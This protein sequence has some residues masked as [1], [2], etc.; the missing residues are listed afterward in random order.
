MKQLSLLNL[1]NIQPKQTTLYSTKDSIKKI[2]SFDIIGKSPYKINPARQTQ[3]QL[4]KE[5]PP[6]TSRATQRQHIKSPPDFTKS[7]KPISIS[8]HRMFIFIV[9]KLIFIKMKRK[10]KDNKNHIIS[11]QNR[12]SLK[13][14]TNCI[15]SIKP[16][17]NTIQYRIG[18]NTQITSNLIPQ[19]TKLHLRTNPE[20]IDQE[21]TQKLPSTLGNP[22]LSKSEKLLQQNQQ[23]FLDLQNKITSNIK[24]RNQTKTYSLTTHQPQSTVKQL[25]DQFQ[26]PQIAQYVLQ[27]YSDQLSEFEK[28]E[29]IDYETIYYLAPKN[30][31]KAQRDP[32]GNQFNHGYDNQHGDYKFIKQDQIAFRYEMLDKLGNGSFGYVFKVF[33]HKHRKEMAIKIIKNREKFYQ[34]ALIEIDLLKIINKADNSYCLIKLMNF[35][36]FRNHICMVFELL[37]CNLYEFL[38]LNNFVGLEPDLIRRF[39]IQILQALLYLKA[40]N[41]IHCDLKP[42]N[43]LLK[44]FTKSGLK[45]IDFGSSC[46]ANNKMY[47]YIQSRFYRAPEIIFGINYTFQID[48]WSF[49]CIMAELFLGDSLF[50]SKTEKELLYAQT[51]VLGMPPKEVIDQSPRKVKFFDDKYQLNYKIKENEQTQQLK[52]LPQLLVKAGADFYDFISKCLEWNQFQRLTPEQALEHPW[53]IN[54]LPQSIRNELLQKRTNVPSIIPNNKNADKQEPK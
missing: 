42:E 19:I 30:I 52:P 47:T 1:V 27:H 54:T 16:K 28:K 25:P 7:N 43:I 17:V 33:D 45:V 15:R 6:I 41:I 53:I 50:Q 32:L 11:N 14:R 48:M 40:C 13:N 35:F 46:F 34:Q 37:C 44:E 23:K 51:K 24:Q 36:E 22:N 18:I 31:A 10:L 9:Y 26:L 3:K 4:I 5:C 49:G 29:I 2:R 20:Q 12:S 8:N 39:A 21:V 38:A